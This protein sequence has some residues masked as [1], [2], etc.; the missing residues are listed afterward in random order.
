MLPSHLDGGFHIV[1]Q[2]DELGRPVVV[3]AKSHDVDL[4]HGGREKSEK[5]KAE[6][7]AP[8]SGN[9]VKTRDAAVG[10]STRKTDPPIGIRKFELQIRIFPI[11]WPEGFDI[12]CQPVCIH[13]KSL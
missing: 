7:G 13:V 5:T 8:L 12:A 3:A 11:V 6:Q 4:S 10:K 1:R 9:L 2:D